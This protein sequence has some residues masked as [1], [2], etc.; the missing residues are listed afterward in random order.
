MTNWADCNALCP[1]PA[2]SDHIDAATVRAYE[3]ASV[4]WPVDPQGHH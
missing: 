1:E 2:L 3:R 4:A